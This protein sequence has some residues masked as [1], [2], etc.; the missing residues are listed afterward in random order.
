MFQL[1][2]TPAK[3]SEVIVACAVLHNIAIML[4]EP[5][6]P[7]DDNDDRADAQMPYVG[8]ETGFWIRDHIAQVYF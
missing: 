7:D 4:Q 8:R 6:V 1:R 2:K 5:D 3:A